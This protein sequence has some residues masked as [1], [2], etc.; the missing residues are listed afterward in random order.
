MSS[1]SFEELTV[2]NMRDDYTAQEHLIEFGW[3]VITLPN[4]NYRRYYTQFF[5]Y[6][7]SC[8]PNFDSNDSTTWIR[9][10]LPYSSEKGI[11]KY[12]FGHTSWQWEIREACIPAFQE[13]WNF[14]S[15]SNFQDGLQEE[16]VCSYDGGCFLAPAPRKR[17]Y[18]NW[19]HTDQDREHALEMKNLGTVRGY[20]V[21]YAS[22]QG[23]VCLT[24]VEADDGGL[25]VIEDSHRLFPQV[26]EKD[27]EIGS[28]FK[29]WPT[30]SFNQEGDSLNEELKNLPKV[31]ICASAG[32]IILFD[33]RTMHCNIPP[34]SDQF[35]MCTYVSMA[36]R[37]FLTQKEAELHQIYYQNGNMT[38][39]NTYGSWFKPVNMHPPAY[40]ININ[41]PPILEHVD[42]NSVQETLI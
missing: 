33:S 18:I 30:Y 40:A 32:Q 5:K 26:L 22:I 21:P 41:P 3:A 23:V 20:K 1:F 36:P 39:H 34:R 2:M 13:V 28:R 25:V 4:F 8:N 10:N 7:E 6:L 15:D 24:P 42:L 35:R 31:K 19:F 38:G 9:P 17:K 29:L 12:Y 14:A 11:F 27:P 37:V 16:L